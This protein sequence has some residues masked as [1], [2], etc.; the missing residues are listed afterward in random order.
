MLQPMLEADGQRIR[1]RVPLG[2][3]GTPLDI[4]GPALLLAARA[5]SYL[6]GV[7]LPVDGGLSGCA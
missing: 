7:T 6:T 3:F 2:R 5:G 1:E 4:A